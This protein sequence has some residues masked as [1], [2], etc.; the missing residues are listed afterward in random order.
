MKKNCN[1]FSKEF[2]L[3]LTSKPFNFPN[4]IFRLS[5]MGNF[6]RCCFTDKF[7]GGGYVK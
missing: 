2:I 7:L 5:D 6:I 3:K 4:Y 1:H